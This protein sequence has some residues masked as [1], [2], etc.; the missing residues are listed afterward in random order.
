MHHLK[1]FLKTTQS[2]EFA[3]TPAMSFYF[4]IEFAHVEIHSWEEAK[5]HISF[6]LVLE[7]GW[8][9]KAKQ[10]KKGVYCVA[11]RRPMIGRFAGADVVIHVPYEMPVIIKVENG[12]LLIEDHDIYVPVPETEGQLVFE[13]G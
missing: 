12:S 8:Q 4:H 7:H 9:I 3:I 1:P 6:S 13:R 2:Q 11:K 5:I 10:D